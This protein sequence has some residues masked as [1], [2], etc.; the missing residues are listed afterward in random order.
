MNT[1]QIVLISTF[2]SFFF[3]GCATVPKRIS[4]DFSDNE[5]L[6]EFT[7]AKNGDAI[8]LPVKF[9]GK[10]YSFL[11]DTGSSHTVLD[12]SFR[13]ALGKVKRTEKGITAKGTMD[14]EI[15][16]AP[17]A[18]IGSFNLETCSEVTCLD[19]KMLNLIVGKNI[20]GIIGT[21]FLKEYVVKLDF[22]RGTLSFLNPMK[23]KN[24]DLGIELAMNYHT[25]GD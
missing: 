4:E 9:K 25:S 21:D 11:L 19:L 7:I 12:T 24:L 20:H 8:L 18:Y 10:E 13:L 5:I 15:F 17:K 14:F 22:D 16:D 6:A 3:V 23:L 1:R 2:L